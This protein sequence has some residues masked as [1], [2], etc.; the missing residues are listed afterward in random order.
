[1][2]KTQEI[3]DAVIAQINRQPTRTPA[4]VQPSTGTV[5]RRPQRRSDHSRAGSVVRT[6]SGYAIVIQSAWVRDQHDEWIIRMEVRP[7]Q[8]DEDRLAVARSM[9]ATWTA[10]S[11]YRTTST[12]DDERDRADWDAAAVLNIEIAANLAKLIA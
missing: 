2:M 9:V 1:M 10:Q 5:S 6:T 4:V 11:E 12:P 3:L 8:T 7:P